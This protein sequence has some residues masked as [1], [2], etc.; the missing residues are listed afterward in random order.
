MDR[1]RIAQRP[2]SREAAKASPGSTVISLFLAAML[3]W[4]AVLGVCPSVHELILSTLMPINSV[5]G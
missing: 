2:G 3:Q 1:D 4:A 5:L